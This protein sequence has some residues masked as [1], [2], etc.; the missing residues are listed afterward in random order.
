MID[1]IFNLVGK[2]LVIE[3]AN[4]K[5]F[6]SRLIKIVGCEDGDS[7]LW[8]E[9][10]DKTLWMSKRSIVKSIKMEKDYD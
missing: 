7:E 6:A 1:P 8:F 10:R 5:S 3:L 2:I 9:S 4:G